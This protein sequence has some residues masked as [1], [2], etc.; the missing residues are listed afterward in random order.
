MILDGF[1]PKPEKIN[2]SIEFFNIQAVSR[3]RWSFVGHTLR[4]TTSQSSTTRLAELVDEPNVFGRLIGIAQA[5][6]FA[7]YIHHHLAL[8]LL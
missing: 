8:Y 5:S 7:T 1:Q 3:V 6:I 4:A 2:L